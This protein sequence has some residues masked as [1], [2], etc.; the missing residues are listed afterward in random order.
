MGEAEQTKQSSLPEAATSG[1]AQFV[2]LAF[3]TSRGIGSGA[4]TTSAWTQAYLIFCSGVP[5]ERL[6]RGH[7]L[8]DPRKLLSDLAALRFGARYIVRSK[9]V[10]AEGR[11]GERVGTPKIGVSAAERSAIARNCLGVAP[12]RHAVVDLDH[13]MVHL[14]KSGRIVRGK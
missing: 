7:P 4:N 11:V 8:S 5:F 1:F 14:G 6:Y 3:V 12:A 13:Q 10:A 9:L 2:K